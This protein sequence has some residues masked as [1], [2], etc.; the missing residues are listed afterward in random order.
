LKYIKS[1]LTYIKSNL[2]HFKFIMSAIELNNQLMMEE[3]VVVKKTQSKPKAKTL[4][5]K[6]KK[7]MSTIVAFL[8]HLRSTGLLDETKTIELIEHLPIYKTVEE[9]IQFFDHDLFNVPKKVE[10][11]VIKT[12]VQHYKKSQKPQKV[13]RTKKTNDVSETSSSS[14]KQKRGR[15]PK[16]QI[17][18]LNQDQDEVV[19]KEEDIDVDELAKLIS[20][21]E[22]DNT[23]LV[24]TIDNTKSF[25]NNDSEL[26]IEEMVVE[27]NEMDLEIPPPP[28]VPVPL[29]TTPILTEKK[30][31]T[32]KKEKTGEEKTVKK[33]RAKKTVENIVE[34]TVKNIVE[35][36][37]EHVVESST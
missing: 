5:A 19:T 29:K 14:E 32:P 27:N 18:V 20:E 31:R 2:K 24:T 25:V 7:M 33:P 6:E 21:I 12:M 17:M 4:P 1:S 34:K 36:I 37:V 9:Q 35:N 23:K 30:V 11:E 13:S 10:K 16:Q 28:P 15:K 3:E 8:V 22:L 26:E